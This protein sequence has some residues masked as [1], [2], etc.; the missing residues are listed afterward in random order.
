MADHLVL[1]T[2]WFILRLTGLASRRRPGV[3]STTGLHQTVIPPPMRCTTRLLCAPIAA[4]VLT[5]SA[6]H[7]Q[8]AS[9]PASP[10]ERLLFAVEI[11]VGP[12][13]DSSKPPQ[14]Q[15]YFR[16][17]SAHLR[18][19][20]D[21]AHLL[22]GARYSD[23]GLI[24]ITA[25]DVASVKALLDADPSFAAGTFVYEVHPMN[26]FYPGELKA[27]PQRQP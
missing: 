25:T 19:L 20:R 1:E 7:A 6:S 11:K 2:P 8:I 15:A 3:S 16:E 14:D 13:W 27:R 22:V 21:S 10:P 5:C 12:K 23:K 17:H 26:V 24:V 4:W 18:R 9:S